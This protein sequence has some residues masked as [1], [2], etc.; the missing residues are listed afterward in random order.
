[1]K[2]SWK[3]AP[4]WAN[5]LAVDADGTWFWY[6]LTPVQLERVWDVSGGGRSEY[7]PVTTEWLESLEV[8][9]N[10]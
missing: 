5:W 8:R 1:M 6:E 7:A 9:P 2:P 10:D 4:D 3:D